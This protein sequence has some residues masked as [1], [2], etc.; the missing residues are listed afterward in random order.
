MQP[1]ILPVNHLTE[2]PIDKAVSQRLLVHIGLPVGTGYGQNGK[3]DLLRVLPRYN[4]AARHWAWLAMTDLDQDAECAPPFIQATLPNPSPGMRF[5]VAVRAVEAW[6]MADA[7]RLAAFLD[8]PLNRIPQYPDAELEPKTALVNLARRSRKRA[9]R[10]DMVP[11]QG[12]GSQ[13]GPGYSGRLIEFVTLAHG[14]W[15][16]DVAAQRSDS[17][18]R[19]LEALKTLKAWQPD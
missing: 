12:S 7:E 16:P 5:R 9:I 11:R 1:Y 13:V 14:S 19:C 18:R 2:G 15:R 6:L 8:I 4:Q 17:L 10:Q 3:P